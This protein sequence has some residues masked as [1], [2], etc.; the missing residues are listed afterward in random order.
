MTR[1]IGGIVQRIDRERGEVAIGGETLS[2]LAGIP[3][4][5]TV[6]AGTS[7]TA[8][9]RDRD[10]R[11][12]VIRIVPNTAPRFQARVSYPVPR[13]LPS[14]QPGQSDTWAASTT[15]PSIAS[16]TPAGS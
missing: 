3:I 14:R 2:L 1:I 8:L 6:E 7:V 11:Q 5:A 15:D 16:I 9:V 13:L 4:D 10:G 12:D